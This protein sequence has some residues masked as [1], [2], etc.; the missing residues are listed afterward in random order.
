MLAAKESDL[1]RRIA[2]AHDAAYALELS[3]D[4]L[5][6]PISTAFLD[7]K[8]DPCTQSTFPLEFEHRVGSERTRGTP[9]RSRFVVR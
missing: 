6:R 9:G 4:V 2:E 5:N 8:A 7:G 1:K 3:G